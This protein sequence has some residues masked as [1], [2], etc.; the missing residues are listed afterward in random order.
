M[1]YLLFC[2]LIAITTSL[3]SL[4]QATSSSSPP[5]TSKYPAKVHYGLFQ[6]VPWCKELSSSEASCKNEGHCQWNATSTNQGH[7]EDK[8]GIVYEEER[9]CNWLYT[10]CYGHTVSTPCKAKFYWPAPAATDIHNMVY[11]LDGQEKYVQSRH[12]LSMHALIYTHDNI[13]SVWILLLSRISY[14]FSVLQ[15]AEQWDNADVSCRL[16]S[17]VFM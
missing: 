12:P 15:K 11:K 9:D 16:L 14:S 4:S 8:P 17:H 2:S 7:C 6:L 1:N 3:S 13:I 10:G 5:T